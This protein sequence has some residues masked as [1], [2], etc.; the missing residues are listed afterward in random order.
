MNKEEKLIE[1][2]QKRCV[3]LWEE[4]ESLKMKEFLRNSN[5]KTCKKLNNWLE[6]EGYYFSIYSDGY[7]LGQ[8]NKKDGYISLDFNI[9]FS[10]TDMEN[11]INLIKERLENE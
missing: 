9:E 1:Y 7:K 5:F 2:L 3:E 6:D 10:V 11:I 8:V 4:N